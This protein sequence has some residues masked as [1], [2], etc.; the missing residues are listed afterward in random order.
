[1]CQ[2]ADIFG[3]PNEGVHKQRL[4]GMAAVDLIATAALAGIIT[5][6]TKKNFI[7]VFLALML[8]AVVV[9]KIFCVETALNKKL[10]S[11]QK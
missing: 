7:L 5:Y 3:K 1:M 4:F 2:H 6:F 9:H 8:L 10:F 11:S